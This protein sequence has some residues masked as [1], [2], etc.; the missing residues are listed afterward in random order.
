VYEA[1]EKEYP[2]DLECLTYL[3]VKQA[4][5]APFMLT[6]APPP[7]PPLPL[8]PSPS[9]QRICSDLGMMERAARYSELL[10]KAERKADKQRAEQVGAGGGGA[11][12]SAD[13]EADDGGSMAALQVCGGGS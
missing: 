1:V 10:A 5:V 3:Q 9:L 2:D 11:F 12:A 8:L 7:P 4:R 6:T 13:Q